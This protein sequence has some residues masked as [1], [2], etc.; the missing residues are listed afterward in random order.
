MLNPMCWKSL[1][2]LMFVKTLEFFE[3]GI[4]LDDGLVQCH[5][6]QGVEKC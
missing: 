5:P 1:A 3:W 2:E 6:Q 4:P